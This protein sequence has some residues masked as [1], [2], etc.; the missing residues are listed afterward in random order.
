MS[1]LPQ[2]AI[3]LVEDKLIKEGLQKILSFTL[4]CSDLSVQTHSECFTPLLFTVLLD[5]FRV[6]FSNKNRT[7]KCTYRNKSL[8]VP[9]CKP[10][11]HMS[12][13]VMKSPAGNL[14]EQ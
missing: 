4:L 12:G 13:Y 8:I 5:I 6:T 10:T 1:F 9:L 14:R 3:Y 7:D 2:N 11:R